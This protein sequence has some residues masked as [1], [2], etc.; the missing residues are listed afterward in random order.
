MVGCRPVMP[1]FHLEGSI[2]VAILINSSG[3]I[4][5]AD[6]NRKC[7]CFIS[8]K[9]SYRKLSYLGQEAEVTENTDRTASGDLRASEG[10]LDPL[11]LQRIVT[12]LIS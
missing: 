3:L 7:C 8:C 12:I 9:H 1:L 6:A 11:L 5:T 10:C 2:T 4:R